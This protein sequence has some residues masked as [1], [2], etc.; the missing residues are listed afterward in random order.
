MTHRNVFVFTKGR[1]IHRQSKSMP[2]D[3]FDLFSVQLLK[4]SEQFIGIYR[5]S[6][7]SDLGI[8]SQTAHI[9]SSKEEEAEKYFYSYDF[10]SKS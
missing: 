4:Y 9:F 2:R 8:F 6:G 5:R 1:P 7:K 3:I 10:P